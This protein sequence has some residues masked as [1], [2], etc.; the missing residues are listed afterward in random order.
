M[1]VLVVVVAMSCVS[2]AVVD[3][4]DVVAMRD[5][6]VATA[7]AMNMVVGRMHLMVA[8]GLAFVVVIVVP[9]M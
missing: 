5:R 4:V 7:I 1:S 2:A 3:V 8:G 9:S 6:H